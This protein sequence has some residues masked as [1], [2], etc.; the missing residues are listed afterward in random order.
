LNNTTQFFL[1]AIDKKNLIEYFD[2][3]D[4]NLNAFFLT[5]RKVLK[6][7]AK[8]FNIVLR[9]IHQDFNVSMID[10]I[11]Y[12]ESEFATLP[13]IISNLDENTI[14]ILK[15]ELISKYNLKKYKTKIEKF[16]K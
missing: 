6:E 16:F 10:I 7:N 9:R 14:S 1:E 2:F 13:T 12:I 15:K 5:E 4:F 3:L 8:T 11:V